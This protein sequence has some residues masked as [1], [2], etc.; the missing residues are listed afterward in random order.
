MS[1]L[2]RQGYVII[3]PVY[4]YGTPL[5]DAMAVLPLALQELAQPGH[6]AV[7]A[8]QSA[9]I[10]FSYGGLTAVLYAAAAADAGLPVPRAL[11]LTAPCTEN[12]YCLDMPA[13]TPAL[14]EGMQAIVIGY[15]DDFDIGNEPAIVWETLSA[16]PLPDRDFILMRSDG[17]GDP[18]IRASHQTT[19]E[20]VDAADWYGIWKLADG[21]L[22][23]AFTDTWCEYALGN[24]PE[25]RFMGTWSDGVPVT[26]LVVTDDPAK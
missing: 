23:C 17:H 16:L 2:A 15:E 20:E 5:E 1:H 19:Y 11:F 13:E 18:P 12:G 8:A 24:T 4:Q 9:A 26:E 14:P 10:G 7:N 3:A 21:L 25:Q 6:A 22:A